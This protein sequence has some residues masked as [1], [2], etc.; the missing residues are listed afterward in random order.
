MGTIVCVLIFTSAYGS[1]ESGWHGYFAMMYSLNGCDCV[2]AEYSEGL[3][4]ICGFGAD[5][6]S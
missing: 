3:A 1:P 2:V 4:K 6:A 5:L